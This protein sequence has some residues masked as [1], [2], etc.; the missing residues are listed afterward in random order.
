M[1][2]GHSSTLEKIYQYLKN[3]GPASRYSQPGI[4]HSPREMKLKDTNIK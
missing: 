4:F 3:I 2:R 1:I